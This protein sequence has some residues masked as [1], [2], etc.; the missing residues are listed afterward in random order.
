MSAAWKTVGVEGGDWCH[1]PGPQLSRPQPPRIQL[2][3]PN[4][5][6]PNP[7]TPLH[8]FRVKL[9]SRQGLFASNRPRQVALLRTTKAG[10]G[11]ARNFIKGGEGI[12]S[13]F[14]SSV[15][16]SAKLI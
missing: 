9:S 6:E 15:L 12:I 10:I 13:T 5:P 8:T 3:D 2:P 11:V 1:D 4:P 7:L 16:F 14:F